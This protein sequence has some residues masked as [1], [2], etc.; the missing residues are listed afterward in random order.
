MGEDVINVWKC[1]ATILWHFE[2]Q[3]S[4]IY[5]TSLSVRLFLKPNVDLFF[6]PPFGYSGP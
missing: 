2:E 1:L 3:K 4:H 5:I 6:F